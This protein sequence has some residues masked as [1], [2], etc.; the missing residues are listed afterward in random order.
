LWQALA[1]RDDVFWGRL[2][3][4]RAV[5]MIDAMVRA[6]SVDRGLILFLGFQ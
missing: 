2:A 6:W 1:H 3:S 5:A 4:I